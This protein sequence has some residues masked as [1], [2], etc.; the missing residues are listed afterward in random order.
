MTDHTVLIDLLGIFAVSIVVVFAFHQVRLPSIPGFLVAGAIIGPH[1]L[2]LVS[3]LGQIRVLVEHPTLMLALVAAVL[4]GKF[5][6]GVLPMLA[7]KYPPR[8]SILT[9]VALAQVGEF[10]FI[11]AQEGRAAGL[12]AE[13]QR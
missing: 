3:D 9:G 7:L 10:S 2:N 13:Q 1:G 11:L 8:S 12:L 5:I 4:V 6:A